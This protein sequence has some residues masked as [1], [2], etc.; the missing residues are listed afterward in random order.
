MHD[1]GCVI[2]TATR[3]LTLAAPITLSREDRRQ[4]VHAI[5]KTGVGKSNFLKT[6]MFHDLQQG[7]DFILLDPLG[8]VAEAVVDA[9]PPE[10]NDDVIHFAPGDD[11]EHCVGFNPLDRV[12]PD[13][14][15]LIAD[16]VVSSFMHIWGGN[17]EDTPR[18]VY[19]LYSAVRLL[20]DAPD[21]AT[22]L[23]LPRLLVDDRYREKL[24]RH[25]RDPVV[26]NYWTHEFAAYDERFRT[27]VI[28]PIQ[29]RVGMLLSPPA[30]RNILGQQRSTMDIPRLMNTRGTLIANLGKGKLGSTGTQLLGALLATAV[31][32]AA[33]ER[34][35]IRMEERRDFTLFVDELQNVATTSFA[36]TLSELRNFRLS[37]VASNQFMSQLPRQ[38]QEAIIGNCGNSIVF[39]VG[40]GEDA[41]R[42]ADELD[43]ANATALS[44]TPNFH[45]W[46]K[47]LRG[48]VPSE[49][50]TIETVLAEPP[51]TGR[52]NAV[53]AHT[54][55]RHTRP[56]A[57][58]EKMVA[59]AM[60]E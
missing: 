44:D 47:L 45:A 41:R 22:L 7:H 53:V 25:C 15:H 30:L 36:S 52:K 48:G 5:G 59:K 39:R 11:L 46:V 3:G 60:F 2:G 37:V 27:Q 18:L 20:L 28:G 50:F 26:F 21:G 38:L 9:V 51:A 58:V 4:H 23:G 24:L 54:R 35:A 32:Q 56:R 42:L 29:T 40:A 13:K 55:A 34:I 43:V 49:A 6:L 14:R 31:A 19:V 1:D 33:E 10:R 12:P 17:L 16:H 8:G 57:A